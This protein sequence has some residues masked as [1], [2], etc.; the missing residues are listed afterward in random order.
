MKP[1]NR[2]LWV[3]LKVQHFFRVL[4]LGDQGLFG[5]AVDQLLHSRFP[6][7]RQRVVIV[8]P[9]DFDVSQIQLI[10][11]EYAEL[12]DILWQLGICK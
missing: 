1:S 8:K 6:V 2:Q 11:G 5:E 10:I 3:V 7:G 9:I 4:E 12:V